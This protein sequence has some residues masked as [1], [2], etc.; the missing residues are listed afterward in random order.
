M[1]AQSFDMLFE[2]GYRNAALPLQFPHSTSCGENWVDTCWRF[3]AA[4]TLP[5]HPVSMLSVC[6][7]SLLT[8]VPSGTHTTS[9]LLFLPYQA[10]SN[11]KSDSIIG[12]M[13]RIHQLELKLQAVRSGGECVYMCI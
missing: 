11:L 2:S 9:I 5:A 13:S 7:S 4:Q 6:L 12:T 10:V 8:S 3:L 1:K